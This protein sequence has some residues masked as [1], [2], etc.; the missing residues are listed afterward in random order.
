MAFDAVIEVTYKPAI[1]MDDATRDKFYRSTS[2]D[3]DDD[4][5]ELDVEPP[6]AEVLAH[7]KRR[8]EKLVEVSEMSI[9]VD[10]IYRDL[11]QR[12][13]PALPFKLPEKIRFQFQVKHMLIATAVLAVV[14]T[15]GRL[16][17]LANVGGVL[18]LAV[19]GG[20]LA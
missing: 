7:E 13:A 11:E 14:L 1:S 9:D 10:E 2:N 4:D 3:W 8:A 18:V 5:V 12:D 15:M 6:D 17:I 16:H 20:A 19:M